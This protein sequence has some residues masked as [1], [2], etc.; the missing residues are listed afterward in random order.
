MNA[1]YLLRLS[2]L[3]L[4][5]F[6]I[7]LAQAGF[8]TNTGAMTAVRSAPTATLL[9]NGKVLVAGGAP[10][11]GL[12]L[13]SAELYNPASGTWT[14]TGTLTD[15]RS[16]HTATLLPNGKVLVAGGYGYL[17]SAELYNPATENWTTTGSL[18]TGRYD[19]TATLLLNGKVMVAGGY[20]T[21]G[22][23]LASAELYDPATGT[24]TNTGTMSTTHYQHTAT[25]LSNGQVLVAGG[26]GGYFSGAAAE[27]YD[28][29][30]GTWTS[31]GFESSQRY[32][33]TATLLPNGQVL[34]AGGYGSG[35]F[36]GS[37]ASTPS[38]DIY[39]PVAGTWT[40]TGS[41][42]TGRYGHTATLLP[43]G[44]VLVAGGT[45]AYYQGNRSYSWPLSSAELYDPAT[46]TWTNTSAMTTTRY[47]HTASLL[48]N[49]N[50]LIAGGS[51]SATSEFYNSSN[52]TV[53]AT[54]LTRPV[55]LPGGEFQFT[56]T[57]TPDVSFIVYGT[58]NLYLNLS[59]WTVFKG[60]V[61]VFSGQYQ[62]TDPQATNNPQRFYR[63]RSPSDGN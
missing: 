9:P 55:K 52:V 58:T 7:H 14:T 13:P 28:Q 5:L 35:Y 30:T 18:G 38:A 4:N 45:F 27:L 46:G 41:L 17:S 56:F 62:F 40:A 61:E 22:L 20:G 32:N 8:F 15:A 59:N 37:Y 23:P 25:L 63:V 10:P 34:V 43:N 1:K 49:G 11:A 19:H 44:K 39:D 60:P 16:Y 3:A 53:T 47:H 6:G 54:L 21:N 26:T 50:T 2:T 51:G 29:A 48:P 42:G 33:H 57:N 36:V 12:Y 24:W 31:A